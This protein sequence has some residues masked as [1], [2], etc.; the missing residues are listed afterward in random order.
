[1]SRRNRPVDDAAGAP[2]EAVTASA[3]LQDRSQLTEQHAAGD[4][5]PLNPFEGVIV[6]AK[7]GDLGLRELL[8]ALADADLVV[9]SA[10]I[11]Q[12]DDSG[13]QPLMFETDD[14]EHLLACFSHPGRAAQ[15]A[16]LA[17]YGLMMIGAEVLQ[18]LQKGVGLVINP[19][20]TLSFELSAEGISR[21]Q[22]G[23]EHSG[24]IT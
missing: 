22:T 8:L 20:Q 23:P 17:P 2:G 11:V 6:Q 16:E 1:M 24:E 19:G 3:A 18:N 14:G 10:E 21:L 7:R 5:Q 15:F 4:G 13:F 9:P 12:P